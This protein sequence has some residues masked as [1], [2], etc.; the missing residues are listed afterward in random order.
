MSKQKQGVIG[1]KGQE[2]SASD[3]WVRVLICDRDDIKYEQNALEDKQRL[4]FSHGAQY[5]DVSMT[6]STPKRLKLSKLLQPFT[7]HCR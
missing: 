4:H 3:E 6:C 2:R 1:R 7:V 5:D